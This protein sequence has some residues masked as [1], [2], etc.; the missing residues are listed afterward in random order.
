MSGFDER[1]TVGTALEVAVANDL[2]ARGITVSKFGQALLDEDV[3]DVLKTTQSLLRWL[4]DLIGWRPSRPR[5]FL[6]DAKSCVRKD[7]PNHSIEMRVLLAAKFTDLPVF[8]ICD[9]FKV[10]P[11]GEVWPDGSWR[12]CCDDCLQKALADP[13]GRLLP[14]RCPE[15]V[16]KSG[17]GSGTPYVLVRRDKCRPP[18]EF[19][20]PALTQ[21]KYA[22]LASKDWPVNAPTGT[23]AWR[24][25]DIQSPAHRKGN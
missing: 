20:G 7:T 23:D 11:S 22:G 25:R 4:P 8:F 6:I 21:S 9:E 16:R 12:A 15:H 18:E 1:F 24:S 10:L 3:R 5:P 14:T 13:T 17:R 19:F 2:T